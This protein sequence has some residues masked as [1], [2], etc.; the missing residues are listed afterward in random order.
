LL[1]TYAV[2]DVNWLVSL[3]NQELRVTGTGVYQ[4]G[5]TPAKQR[6]R[7]DLSVDE[8]PAQHFDSGL[9]A[10]GAAFPN[11]AIT[12][13][14]H[15]ER[16]FDTVFVVNASPAPAAAIHPYKLLSGSTI[17]SGC[18][19]PCVC[20]LG[21]AQPLIGSFDLV[22]LPPTPLFAEYAVTKVDWMTE[23]ATATPLTLVRGG[24]FYE[25]GGEAAVEQQ[26]SLDLTVGDE[27]L[28]HFDSG[29]VPGG[30]S[31]PLI[32]VTISINGMRCGDTVMVIKAAPK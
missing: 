26:L 11:I 18:F 22:D 28:T 32:D 15:S 7:L 17:Q 14:L 5:G 12:I 6:L 3:P 29:L 30:G 8:Q 21:A 19:P 20:P 2:T 16:C 24:G 23:S 31:F 25:V 4:I 9:V 13:S 1:T 27:P 10:P